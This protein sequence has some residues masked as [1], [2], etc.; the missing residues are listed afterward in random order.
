LTDPLLVV[1]QL[2]LSFPRGRVWRPVVDDVSFQVNIGETV[3]LVGESGSGKS[4]I[5][6]STLCLLPPEAR[7]DQGRI[8]FRGIELFKLPERELDRLRGNELCL[9]L[10]EPSQAIN[11]VSRVKDWLT[12]PL[13]IHRPTARSEFAERVTR[14]L[15]EVGLTR[16]EKKLRKYPHELAHGDKKLL[17][18]A[19]ALLCRPTLLVLDEPTQGL[20]P[21]TQ[22]ALTD[23]LARLKEKLGLSLL[24]ITHDL[25][26]VERSADVVLVMYAGQIVERG[27]RERV[28]ALRSHPYTRALWDSAIPAEIS[29]PPEHRRLPVLATTS[30]DSEGSGCRFRAAC[31]Y[32]A[33]LPPGYERCDERNPELE[34]I[35]AGHWVRCYF[36][37]EL[38][39]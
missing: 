36:A 2:R 34:E 35:E 22:L 13:K 6:L 1:E 33:Q 37:R 9:V 19:S 7:L 39:C 23:N 32:R 16:A 38:S 27:P 28:L 10:Q 20:D 3:A 14:V 26:L 11:P 15:A 12:Q 5:G 31:W 30:V 29:G 8:L 17:M 4:L 18:L 21:T 24:T 25:T